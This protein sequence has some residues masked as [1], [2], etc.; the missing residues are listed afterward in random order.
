MYHKAY[1]KDQATDNKNLPENDLSKI[2]FLIT[3]K[4]TTQI[5]DSHLL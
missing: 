3:V 5:Q 4:A 2:I 1:V